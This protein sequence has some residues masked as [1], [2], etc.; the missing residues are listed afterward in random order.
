[1]KDILLDENFSLWALYHNTSDALMEVRSKEM[2]RFGLTHIEHRL[3][4]A[5]PIIRNST[6]RRV[7][8]S[9]LSRWLFRKQ[10]SISELLTRMEKKGL[11]KRESHPT[12]KKVRL[13]Q[14]TKKG[15]SL[16]EKGYK[17]GMSIVK[18]SI[19]SLSEEEQQQLWVIA[20]KLRKA[21]FKELELPDRR[22]F[23]QFL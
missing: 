8:A 2:E 16:R 21:A 22:P 15:K 3:L 6:G 12:N 4:L 13:I 18:K 14:L 11:V 1:M 7:T 9:D 17:E 5:I 19:S 20:G 10:S 23:P